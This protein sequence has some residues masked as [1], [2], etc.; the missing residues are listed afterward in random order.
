MLDMEDRDEDKTNVHKH[1]S[2]SIHTNDLWINTFISVLK[3]KG[4]NNTV[5]YGIHDFFTVKTSNN[6]GSQPLWYAAFPTPPYS[7]EWNS[8]KIPSGWNK[9][10][11]KIWQ[12][13]SSNDKQDLNMMKKDFF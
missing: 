10:G 8:P 12:F 11:W 6:F 9:N 1:W 2:T 4:Y 13:T 3:S 7:P 5:L